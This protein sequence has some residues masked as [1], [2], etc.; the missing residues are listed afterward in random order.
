MSAFVTLI[1]FTANNLYGL[2]QSYPMPMKDFVWL[3]VEEINS[4]NI[5]KMN[6]EQRTGYILEVDLDYPEE[7]HEEHGSFPLAP[8]RLIITEK[9]LSPY[10][11][12]NI[13]FM[14]YFR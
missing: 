13:V 14:L 2:G 3:T 5:M 10:A 6:D 7:L 12:G 9:Q 4:L 8:E 11:A 1:F